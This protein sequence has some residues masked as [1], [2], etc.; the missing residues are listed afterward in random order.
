ME[1]LIRAVELA[2]DA[3]R[4]R[5]DDPDAPIERPPRSALSESIQEASMRLVLAT[6]RL[7]ESLPWW[8]ARL[9]HPVVSRMAAK[10]GRLTA[11]VTLAEPAFD[12]VVAGNAFATMLLL[13]RL[14]EQVAA[15][16][17]LGPIAAEVRG[18]RG[19]AA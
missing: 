9:L 12:E 5:G 18:H 15:V 14:D 10:A 17:A 16:A 2:A 7:A 19:R 4:E 13:E 11:F 3:L 1:S 6:D 8:I